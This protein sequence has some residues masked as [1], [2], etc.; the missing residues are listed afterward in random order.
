MLVYPGLRNRDFVKTSL[1]SLR[2]GKEQKGIPDSLNNVVIPRSISDEESLSA[3]FIGIKI[4]HI[5]SK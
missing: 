5:R 2:N 3:K 4:S 1:L